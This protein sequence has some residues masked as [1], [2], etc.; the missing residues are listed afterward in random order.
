MKNRGMITKKI[1]ELGKEIKGFNQKQLRLMA[2]I[3]YLAKNQQ[4]VDPRKIDAEEREIL[5]SWKEQGFGEF[6]INSFWMT[7]KFYMIM[8]EI[9]WEGY[10]GFE[11][12][13]N[14]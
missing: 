14:A 10:C 8:Q 6:G 11:E 5:K 13:K 9:L 12:V 3:D 4:S 7:K 2:Y 1:Q